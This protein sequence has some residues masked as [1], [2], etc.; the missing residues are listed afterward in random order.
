MDNI[1]E[2]FIAVLG[3]PYNSEH[4]DRYISF[5]LSNNLS[6]S[7][8]YFEYH[9]IFPQSLFNDDTV[10]KLKYADHVLAHRLLVDAYPIR[11]FI[12]PLNFMLSR[13]DKLDIEYRK[14]ISISAKLSWKKFKETPNYITW[15]NK[16]SIY[17]NQYMK[18]G[19][20][21]YLSDLRFS[22]Q[23]NRDKVST[24][25]KELWQQ[26]EYRAKIILAM[27]LERN[28]SEGK[29]RMTKS[30]TKRWNKMTEQQRIDFSQ[31]MLYINS[32]EEK[33]KDASKKIKAKWQDEEF[34]DKM[35]KRKTRGSDG[36]ALAKRW[37]D[38]IFREKMLLSR[39]KHETNK[40]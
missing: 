17:M 5:V 40:G 13:T 20:S 35:S 23:K 32:N 21:K 11:E 16:R 22:N 37:A 9:H 28:S 2:N 6:D 33:R 15:R 38:P 8:E 19:G 7:D 4:L 25:F 36:S 12:R 24:Q 29:L 3:S 31:K 34:K 14:L 27:K 10:V 18:N 30:A 39:K 1:K 26:E